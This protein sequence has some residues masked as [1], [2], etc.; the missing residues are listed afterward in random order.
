M[1][2]RVH[3][4]L[5]VFLT[6]L[7]VGC[8]ESH[9]RLD[10]ADFIRWLSGER[11]TVSR[12]LFTD[13][14][15]TINSRDVIDFKVNRISRNDATGV[16]AATVSFRVVR[17]SA[18]VEVSEAVIRYTVSYSPGDTAAKPDGRVFK[19]VDFTPGQVRRI[20]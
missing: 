7:L 17:G 6:H 8:S 4:L 13:E 11:I 3:L 15:W 1:C 9:P 16:Y 2:T 14:V 19:F 18:V 12:G 20:E 5:L 10:D